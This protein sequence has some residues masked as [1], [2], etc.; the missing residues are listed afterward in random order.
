MNKEADTPQ[1]QK[2]QDHT[3]SAR[4][5]DTIPSPSKGSPGQGNAQQQDMAKKNPSTDSNSQYKG[6][7]K[8]EDAKKHAS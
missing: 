8:P 2:Q 4:T 7:Q 5:A 3:G 1:Q 6:Q